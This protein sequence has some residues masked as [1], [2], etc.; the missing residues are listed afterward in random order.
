MDEYRAAK[1]PLIEL[2][3]SVPKHAV[4]MLEAWNSRA[5]D[6]SI[7]EYQQDLQLRDDHIAEQASRIKELEERRCEICGYAEHHREHTGCLRVFVDEQAAEISRLKAL[8]EK[9]EYLV[10]SHWNPHKQLDRGQQISN[11]VVEY[12]IENIVKFKGNLHGPKTS[13]SASSS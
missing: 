10:R 9:I 11:E 3:R 1:T 6:V 12:I 2:L 13:P 4:E 5:E 7:K 8:I